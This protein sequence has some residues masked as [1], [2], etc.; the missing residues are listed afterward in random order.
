MNTINQALLARLKLNRE[1][2]LDDAGNVRI[3]LACRSCGYNLRSIAGTGQ[4]P[5]CGQP[6]EDALRDDRPEHSNPAWLKRTA[7]GGNLFG[8]AALLA[9]AITLMLIAT[10]LIAEHTRHQQLLTFFF[11]IVWVLILSTIGLALAAIWLLTS[12]DPTRHPIKRETLTRWSAR[13]GLT[14]GVPVGFALL[15]AG[16]LVPFGMTRK[17]LEA[18]AFIIPP[19]LL[20]AGLITLLLYLQTLATRMADWNLVRSITSVCYGLGGCTATGLFSLLLSAW[21]GELAML[22]GCCSAVLAAL[23]GLWTLLLI[24]CVRQDL[25]A[26]KQRMQWNS[27]SV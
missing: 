10:A 26:A 4:C 8:C 23:L 25:N 17:T 24:E 13:L 11:V 15:W 5:E 18:A 7:L 21:I 19:L 9:V 1:A 14:A 6:V 22:C 27:E 20:A 12:K 2:L 16:A 3:D